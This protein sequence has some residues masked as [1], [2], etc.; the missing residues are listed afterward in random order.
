ML[1]S[2]SGHISQLK[3]LA[4]WSPQALPDRHHVSECGG[5][6]VGFEVGWGTTGGVQGVVEATLV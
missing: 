5:D 1:L 4:N 3:K 6:G 2:S